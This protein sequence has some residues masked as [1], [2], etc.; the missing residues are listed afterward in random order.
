MGKHTTQKTL[1]NEDTGEV[2]KVR[3]GKNYK[4]GY[5]SITR[6]L[7]PKLDIEDY[8][9]E[10]GVNLEESCDRPMDFFMKIEAIHDVHQLEYLVLY[11][12][13][14]TLKEI[15]TTLGNKD[16]KTTLL[17]ANKLQTSL[18]NG[19]NGQAF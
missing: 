16:V 17:L 5:I 7:A 18:K 2:I 3:S 13:G 9:K 19:A 15:C 8:D 10:D 4:Y 6:Y 11:L 1:Y 14:Y 12:M